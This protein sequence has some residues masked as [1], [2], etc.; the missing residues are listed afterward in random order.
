MKRRHIWLMVFLALSAIIISLLLRQTDNAMVSNARLSQETFAFKHSNPIGITL[1]GDSMAKGTG[2]EIGQGFSTYIPE[3]LKDKTTRDISLYNGGIDELKSSG[4]LERLRSGDL[5]PKISDS[6]VLVLSIGGNDILAIYYVNDSE[7]LTALKE[8][9]ETFISNLKET[10]EIIRSKNTEALIVF[11]GLYNPQDDGNSF[12]YN[13]LLNSWNNATRKVL[14]EDPLGV[15]IDTQ[16]IFKS[17]LKAYISSDKLHP[18]SA[19]YR[20]VS[21]KIAGLVK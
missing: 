19:G 6:D 3:Y 13:M 4:L 2:D 11:P 8:T 18:S 14:E 15:F 20:A 7:K 10:L 1:I 5:D 9:Q 12:L 17:D 21:E 16:D